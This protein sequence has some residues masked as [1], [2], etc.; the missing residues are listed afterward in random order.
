LYGLLKKGHIRLRI[1]IL[2][3]CVIDLGFM[4]QI[5]RYSQDGPGRHPMT[6][7]MV[8]MDNRLKKNLL[9]YLDK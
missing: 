5:N 7:L 2:I 6:S 8:E 3:A 1:H 9:D 4:V